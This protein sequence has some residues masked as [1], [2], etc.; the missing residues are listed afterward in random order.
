MNTTKSSRLNY[1]T[2]CVRE[3]QDVS[4]GDPHVLP[5]HAS[6]AFS[7]NDIESSIDVFKGDAEGYVY[8]RY[9]NPTIS[10]VEKKLA[11][12][13]TIDVEEEGFCIMTGSG[14]AAISTFAISQ[15][16]AGDA[17][18]TQANLYGGTTEIFTKILSKY[19]IEVV[20][21]D[22]SD[23]NQV[24]DI[25]TKNENIK[26]LYC[27]SPSNPT[28]SCIDIE[29]IAA[30]GKSHNVTTAIDNTF[31]T[32]YLQRPLTLGIDYVLHSTTKFLNGHGN[33]LAGAIIGK[34][35]DQRKNIWNHMKL[36]GTNCNPFDAWLVHNGLKTLSVRMDRHCDNALSIARHLSEH[37]KVKKVNYPGLQN[38]AYHQIAKKQMSQYGAM[39]SFEIDGGLDDGKKFMNET[40]LCSITATLGNVD[41]LLLHPATS[42]HLNI[43]K[44]IRE[45]EGITDGLIRVSV[46]IENKEDLIA[47][48]EQALGQL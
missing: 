13:E 46:G 14:L 12:L 41:T 3:N 6:S 7:Y 11:A 24:Q 39:L 5:I 17:M 32:S 25:L 15:L 37:P 44:E 28:L 16:E 4:N 45:Q 27:E 38:N 1:D 30:L 23:L 8:S 31:S 35:T 2:I 19:G 22:L 10:F 48:M 20:L 21:T 36:I 9:G 33:G 42:S 34:D 29:K 18:L 40:R 26:L 47:D 43:P